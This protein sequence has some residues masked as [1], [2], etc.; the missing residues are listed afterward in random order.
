MSI[1]VIYCSIVGEKFHLVKYHNFFLQRFHTLIF[2]KLLSLVLKYVNATLFKK[3][4]VPR[5]VRSQ[6]QWT[7]IIMTNFVVYLTETPIERISILDFFK[8]LKTNTWSKWTTSSPNSALMDGITLFLSRTCVPSSK[9]PD[10]PTWFSPCLLWASLWSW[11][12]W[13]SSCWSTFLASSTQP[14]KAS[15]QFNR[16]VEKLFRW[17]V[18]SADDDKQWLTYW[19]VFS[20]T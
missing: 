19:I 15:R 5:Q 18:D 13:L 1:F 10:L 16:Q 14:S 2:H 6:I 9:S 3:I 4:M 8:I 17:I 11:S 7:P 12:A 20:L